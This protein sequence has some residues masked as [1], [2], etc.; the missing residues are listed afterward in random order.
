[1]SRKEQFEG[2]RAERTKFIEWLIEH[3]LQ[4]CVEWPF[5]PAKPKRYPLFRYGVYA[6]RYVC[7]R[8]HGKA[9]SDRP[10]AA[11]H[12]GNYHCVN[13]R[14]LFWKTPLENHEDMQRHGTMAKG[15]RSPHAKL[16]LADVREIRASQQSNRKLAKR[17]NVSA[18]TI[19]NARRGITYTD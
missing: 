8:M 3:P 19:H 4:E 12:C 10:F 15:I 13:P 6:H 9:P 2:L 11:H 14:H 18:P 5:T 17:Y 16:S 7:E 1:M